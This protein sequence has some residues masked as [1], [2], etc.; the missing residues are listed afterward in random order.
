MSGMS[1]RLKQTALFPVQL[2]R[3]GKG[4][5]IADGKEH[6]LV[7]R[8][9]RSDDDAEKMK[10][11]AGSMSRAHVYA[12]SMPYFRFT[13]SSFS[14]IGFETRSRVSTVA[15]V[16]TALTGRPK[17]D[18]RRAFRRDDR[19]HSKQ[20]TGVEQRP[21]HTHRDYAPEHA[22]RKL[23]PAQQ[24]FLVKQPGKGSPPCR[25]RTSATASTPCPKIKLETKPDTA[26]VRKPAS[27]PECDARN[28][29]DR[30]H[31]LEMGQP[32]ENGAR[33]D[34]MPH[35][36]ARMTSSRACGLRF[37]HEKKGDHR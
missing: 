17:I 26:P 5:G 18:G 20:R 33:G 4:A 28:D 2:D 16:C 34:A 30:G 24:A 32:D 19:A 23:F 25:T 9:R 1:A 15:E 10:L 7:E 35:I 37:Q 36:T 3:I 27:A 21:H 29:D 12:S 8:G 22:Q 31:G 13:R 11:T 14:N 6:R